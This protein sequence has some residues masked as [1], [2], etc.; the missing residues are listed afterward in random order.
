M[1]P[2]LMNRIEKYLQKN[3]PRELYISHNLLSFPQKCNRSDEIVLQAVIGGTFC[4]VAENGTPAPIQANVLLKHSVWRNSTSSAY[5]RG[6]CE[7]IN[8]VCDL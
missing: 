8:E 2:E 5:E 1:A 3:R 7:G 4:S 6:W